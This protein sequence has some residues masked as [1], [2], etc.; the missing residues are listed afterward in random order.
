MEVVIRLH[1]QTY[2]NLE[3]NCP[4][5]LSRAMPAESQW[6]LLE[7]YL[8][9]SRFDV[10]WIDTEKIDEAAERFRVDPG[11]GVLCDLDTAFDLIDNDEQET[12]VASSTA[13]PATPG[14]AERTR[15]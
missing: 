8:L 4:L 10:A 12:L 3:R 7:E 1:S 2:S 9:N 14:R 15:P 11:S 5:N 6:D 13:S